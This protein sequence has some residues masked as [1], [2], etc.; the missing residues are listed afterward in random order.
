MEKSHTNK[1]VEIAKETHGWDYGWSFDFMIEHLKFMKDYYESDEYVSDDSCA[2]EN[3]NVIN[4]MLYEYESYNELPEEEKKEIAKQLDVEFDK[5]EN[6][7][8]FE[9]SK[10]ELDDILG[11]V[12][13]V[14][15]IY[16]NYPPE[17]QMEYYGLIN[18]AQEQHYINFIDLLKDD[19]RKLWD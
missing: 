19:F 5:I 18:K 9:D 7:I 12:I 10:K 14:N 3:L 11:E 1:L 2:K 8:E 16:K 15:V 4:K 13:K 17:I 6:N